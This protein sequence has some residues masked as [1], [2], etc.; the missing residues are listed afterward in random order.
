[1]FM[2]EWLKTL[3]FQDLGFWFILKVIAW[4]VAVILVLI[5]IQKVFE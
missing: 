3:R 1:M 5:A 4:F 2:I